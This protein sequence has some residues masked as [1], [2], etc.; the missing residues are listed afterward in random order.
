MKTLLLGALQKAEAGG[1]F[2]QEIIE[3]LYAARFQAESSEGVTVI[4]TTEAGGGVTFGAPPPL[5]P[6]ST[7]S[8]STPSR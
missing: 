6:R 3:D 4:S 8:A 2:I 7:A 5:R 1:R